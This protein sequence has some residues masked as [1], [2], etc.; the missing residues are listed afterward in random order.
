MSKLGFFGTILTAG[1]VGAIGV[2]VVTHLVL[3]ANYPRMIY[4]GQYGMI[5]MLTVPLGWLLGT[6]LGAVIAYQQNGS[7]ERPRMAGLLVG[8]IIIV[9]TIGGTVVFPIAIMLLG[10]IYSLFHP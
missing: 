10:M 8:L 5:F 2:S 6:P 7:K 9:G 1:V 3:T 4:D